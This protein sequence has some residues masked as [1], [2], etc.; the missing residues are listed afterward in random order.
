MR[1]SGEKIRLG[2]RFDPVSHFVASACHPLLQADAG[3]LTL[4]HHYRMLGAHAAT[5]R[6]GA[7]D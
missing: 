2:F 1:R 7:A 6:T 4:R 5:S 3:N